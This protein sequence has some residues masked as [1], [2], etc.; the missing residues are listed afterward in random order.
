MNTCGHHQPICLADKA[1]SHKSGTD[2]GVKIGV[3]IVAILCLIV[4]VAVVVVL[5]VWQWRRR[6]Q[7]RQFDFKPMTY[8]DVKEKDSGDGVAES[9]AQ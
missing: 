6:Q 8:S 9:E 2:R 7:R 1:E 3:P 5:V 4:V